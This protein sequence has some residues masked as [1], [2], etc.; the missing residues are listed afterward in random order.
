MAAARFAG[1]PAADAFDFLGAVPGATKALTYQRVTISFT[2]ARL[3]GL[4]LRDIDPEKVGEMDAA[5]Q[6]GNLQ[7][8]GQAV[9][10]EQIRMD[11]LKQFFV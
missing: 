2:R 6:I 10:Q 3:D 8:V 1:H 11:R 9:A 4:N 7:R 5:D